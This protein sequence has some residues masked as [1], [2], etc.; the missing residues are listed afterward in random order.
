MELVSITRRISMSR[1]LAT[2]ALT[3]LIAAVGASSAQAAVDANHDGLPDRWEKAHHLSLQKKQGKLDPD[4]D[5]LSNRGEYLAHT[6]PHLADTD[7]D[8]V[9][10][11]VDGAPTNAARIEGPSSSAPSEPGATGFGGH[12]THY[13]QGSGFGGFLTIHND[14]T[15]ADV[16]EFFG[17]KTDLE[18]A[19]AQLG[20]YAPCDKSNL[21]DGTP[22]TH[23]EHAVNAYGNDVW[24]HIYLVVSTVST[25]STL[26][27]DP[28][29]ATPAAYGSVF[30]FDNGALA[31]VRDNNG[32]HVT[33]AAGAW[34]DL[35]CGTSLSGPFTACSSDALKPGR[36]VAQAV[37]GVADGQDRWSKVYL[38]VTP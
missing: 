35:E 36:Q 33:A 16:T 4:H 5:G 31:L 8:G 29:P 6:D 34:T 10:D 15:G 2:A 18:C 13:A 26:P 38:V 1:T 11:G 32:E 19:T 12:V 28:P 23:A 9:K 17:E 37:H 14:G 21:K 30:T 24:T 25:V 22:V 27:A 7:G 3:V 20:P